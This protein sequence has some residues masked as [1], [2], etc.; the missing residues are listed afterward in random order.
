MIDNGDSLEFAIDNA[1]HSEK[2]KWL[3]F[4]EQNKRNVNRVYPMM[5]W[6]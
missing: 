1:A 2:E 4:D 5:E 3:L 6:E